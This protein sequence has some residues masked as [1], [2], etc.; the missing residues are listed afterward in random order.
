[1]FDLLCGKYIIDKH[2]FTPNKMVNI[3]DHYDPYEA[4][5]ERV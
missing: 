1:M 5:C 3:A 4:V 2:S